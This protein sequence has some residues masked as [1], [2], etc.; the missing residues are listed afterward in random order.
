MVV[1][2]VEEEESVNSTYQTTD[3]E[4]PKSVIIG[5]VGIIKNVRAIENGWSVAVELVGLSNTEL[6]ILIHATNA[7]SLRPERQ[8]DSGPSESLLAHVQAS[9]KIVEDIRLGC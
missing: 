1:F 9:N 3:S 8:E 7:T 6:N 5:G 4:E 2:E